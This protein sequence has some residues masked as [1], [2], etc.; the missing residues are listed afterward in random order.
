MSSPRL[1]RS[2]PWPRPDPGS[3]GAVGDID[4]PEL[5]RGSMWFLRGFSVVFI[6]VLVWFLVDA[7]IG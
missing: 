7:V 2:R 3:V 4:E 5:G 6:A 1:W